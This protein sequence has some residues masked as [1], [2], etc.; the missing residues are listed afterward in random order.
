MQGK[1]LIDRWRFTGLGVVLCLLAA[2]F[3]FE[4]KIA[5]YSPAPA[6]AAISAAKLQ[7]AKAPHFVYRALGAHAIS[8]PAHLVHLN[9]QLAWLAVFTLLAATLA[10]PRRTDSDLTQTS[11]YLGFSPFRFSRP[12]PSR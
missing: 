1:N 8:S 5:W 3:S 4:A 2:L 6:Q 10:P 11:T 7:P 12:P 9:S